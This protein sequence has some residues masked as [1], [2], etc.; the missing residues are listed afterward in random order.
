MSG[1]DLRLL[2]APAASP[3]HASQHPDALLPIAM[4]AHLAGVTEAAIYAR[5]R[6]NDFPRPVHAPGGQR[7]VAGQVT[8]YLQRSKTT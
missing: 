6:R 8:E 3:M 7:W 1:L 5:L 2:R 4:V